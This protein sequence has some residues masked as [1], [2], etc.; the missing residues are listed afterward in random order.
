MF[1]NKKGVSEEKWSIRTC[2][3]LKS[4]L[5]AHRY[6]KNLR[7]LKKNKRYSNLVMILEF[8]KGN[9]DVIKNYIHEMHLKRESICIL[10]GCAVGF[11]LY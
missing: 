4:I 11:P 7:L 2:V 3:L 6:F 1:S 10:R 5:Q 9:S 8:S